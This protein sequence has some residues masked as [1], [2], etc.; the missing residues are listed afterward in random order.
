MRLATIRAGNLTAAVRIDGEKMTKTGFPDVGKLLLESDWLARASSADG[1][2]ETLDGVEYAPVVPSPRKIICVGLNYRNHILEMGRELPTHP[3][4]FA[5][6][7]EALVGARDEIVLPSASNA[8]DWE[9]ELAVVIGGWVSKAGEIG[10]RSAIAGLSI[11]ND[12]T[13]R[14][15]QYR[16][17]QWL[18][19]KTFERSCPLGPVLVTSDELALGAPLEL[20]AEVNG[21]VVQCAKTNDLVFDC[22]QLVS[23][24][25]NIVTLAPG[26]IIATGTPGGVGHART[27]SRYLK[28][29]D[30]LTTTISGIGVLKNRCRA[31]RR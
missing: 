28:D 20:S 17:T 7:P 24:I 14:D 15:W 6:F 31:E 4:L 27:P 18:Q 2:S 22:V 13:A 16:T 25:S 10:A 12:V 3:T 8:M 19:G 30:V 1:P 11:I 21:E 9:A 23:Y 5:K 29:G 26:D